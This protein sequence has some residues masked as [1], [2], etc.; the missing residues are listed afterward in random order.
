MQ[1]DE[2]LQPFTDLMV[3]IAPNKPGV[4]TIWDH[5]EII[6]I[7]KAEKSVRSRLEAHRLGNEGPCT[8]NATHFQ[9]E[10]NNTPAKRE[11]QLIREYLAEHGKLPRC[12][13]VL[14]SA[15]R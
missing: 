4:Y 14:P 2:Q 9:V 5:A 10:E 6:Y 8:M 15:L 3:V 13:E 1:V 12:N 11:R 7:G